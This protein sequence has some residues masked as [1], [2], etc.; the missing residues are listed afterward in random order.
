MAALASVLPAQATAQADG[1]PPSFVAASRAFELHSDQR[2]NLHD[3]LYARVRADTLD[4]HGRAATAGDR[5]A[6][7][8][9]CLA[10]MDEA[11]SAGWR[12]AEVTYAAIMDRHH[13]DGPAIA[14]RYEV[15]GFDVGMEVEDSVRGPVLEALAAAE[16]AYRACWWPEHDARNREWAA[17]LL[18]R[19]VRHEDRL[20][21]RL[22]AAFGAPWP[23]R[24]RVDVAGW[25]GPGGANTVFEPNHIV[26]SAADPAYVGDAALEMIFHEASHTLVSG[27]R[28]AIAAAI[29]TATESLDVEAPRILW[30]VLL[31][32][33]AGYETRRLLAEHGYP[34]YSPYLYAQG[35][36]ANAW[37][38]LRGPIERH[39]EG[40]L[41][42]E[43][44]MADAVR[45][46]VAA[47]AGT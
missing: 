45:E 46:I 37:P 33:T 34:S 11:S 32:H 19:L 3:F 42:G 24:M 10:G 16:A 29:R 23:A 18:P 21:A 5:R 41:R 30:H 28:G 1:A 47:I 12:S 22:A 2:L 40:Y 7:D 44:D 38:S 26:V 9:A 43:V 25:A 6:K 15:A 35:L 31:F 36:Y 39:W 4:A 8:E 13:F 27:R 17:S 14:I 20:M